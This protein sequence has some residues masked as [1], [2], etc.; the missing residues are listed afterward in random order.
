M[1]VPGPDEWDRF[2]GDGIELGG[3]SEI[4]T[5][6]LDRRDKAFEIGTSDAVETIAGP[7]HPRDDPPVVEPDDE[8]HAHGHTARDALD[9]PNQR[10]MVRPQWHA[11]D[12]PHHTVTSVEVR[13][14]DQR[15]R[16]VTPDDLM[17]VTDRCDLPV[18]MLP[19]SEQRRE[20]GAGVESGEA[21]PID[22]P[23]GPH[24]GGRMG[25][26]DQSVGVDR[27]GRPGP[28]LLIGRR[29]VIMLHAQ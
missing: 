21:E 4:L 5:L 27:Q 1:G 12:H 15:V 14:K 25:V 9:D 29:T 8:L 10:G 2:S 7:S 28:G 6:G 23:V 17:D 18:A 3:C 20:A 16:P 24:E 11:V 13:L 26:A 22:R 19:P